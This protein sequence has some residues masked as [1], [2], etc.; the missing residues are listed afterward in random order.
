MHAREL[1][2][3]RLECVRKPLITLKNKVVCK[4]SG[5]VVLCAGGVIAGA[6]NVGELA[7]LYLQKAW[8]IEVRWYKNGYIEDILI[9]VGFA[10]FL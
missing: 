3:A 9:V 6:N 8:K 4:A 2:V 7:R 1:N 5:L 10:T